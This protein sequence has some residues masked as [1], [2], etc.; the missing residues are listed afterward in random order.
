MNKKISG[1]KKQ[2]ALLIC[3]FCFLIGFTQPTTISNNTKISVLTCGIGDEMYTLFGH[4]AL[5]V[6]DED[7]NF[8]VVYNWGMFDFRTP[9]FY[10]RFVKGDLLYYLDVDNF[11]DFIYNYTIDKREVFEQELNLTFDEKL[12]VWNEIN[13][14]L[15]SKDRYYTYGFIDNNCTTKVVDLINK[16]VEKPILYNFP[17]NN[18]SYRYLL[19]EGLKNHYFQKLGI[20]L[21]FGYPTNKNSELIF[22]PVKLKEG[23][24]HNKYIVKSEK[25]LNIVEK[26]PQKFTINS[27]YTLWIIVLVMLLLIKSN[28]FQYIYFGASTL[29]SLF[30]LTVALYTNHQELHF[31]VLILFYNPLIFIGLLSSKRFFIVIGMILSILSLFFF[32]IELLKVTSPLIVLNLAN[33]LAL[34]LLKSKKEGNFVLPK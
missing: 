30:L 25:K 3:C 29:F 14:Q 24:T 31:N 15:K 12:A 21:L 32:G 2:I 20:N 27:I 6:V 10:S 18:H 28:K 33:I 23:L 17:T 5:R 9:N 4:T 26:L 19:N 8:D 16:V 34:F 13:R 11:N 22:L 7:Q 1:I